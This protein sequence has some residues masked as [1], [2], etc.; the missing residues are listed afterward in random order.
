VDEATARALLEGVSPAPS[1]RRWL[2]LG[3]GDAYQRWA[4]V[5]DNLAEGVSPRKQLEL[6][7]PKGPF[8][9][10]ERA[11][12]TLIAPASYGRY[13]GFVDAVAS[14]DPQAFARA[15]RA[16]HPAVEAAYRALGYPGASLDRATALALSR[17]ERAPARDG[18]VEVVG[19]RGLYLFAD[20]ELERL[21][22]VEKHLLRMGP[23]N[24]R[25]LQGKARELR[26]ALALPPDVARQQP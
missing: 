12:R 19:D 17:I 7:A 14:V 23:N 20:P 16:L 10:V 8:A 26:E 11:G 25:V 3:L 6:F 1:L 21:G 15:Y 4:V 24:T 9:V 22:E 5:T 13:D 18:E 2:G